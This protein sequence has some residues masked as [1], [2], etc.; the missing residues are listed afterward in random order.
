MDYRILKLS[1]P[2][3]TLP[4]TQLNNELSEYLSWGRFQKKKF[5]NNISYD[6]KLHVIDDVYSAI[7]SNLYFVKKLGGKKIL[8]YKNFKGGEKIQFSLPLY[9]ECFG[10]HEE[11]HLTEKKF[12]RIHEYN[13]ETYKSLQSHCHLNLLLFF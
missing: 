6:S 4:T 12:K 1:V 3:A 10:Y 11:K 5:K 8:E 9:E 2:G 13:L 7:A